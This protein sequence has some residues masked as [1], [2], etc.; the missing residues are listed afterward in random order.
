MIRVLTVDDSAFMRQVLV[1]M[2]Q[3]EGDIS[4]VATAR[5][6]IEAL[7]KQAAL[8]A[9][10]VTLD[11]EMPGLNGIDTLKKLMKIA[12]CPV[13]MISGQTLEGAAATI[14]ALE[15][16]ALDFMAKPAK[17]SCQSLD[18]HGALLREKVRSASLAKLHSTTGLKE[19]KSF[20]VRGRESELVLIGAS[21]G[22]PRA[23]Q[24]IITAL[25]KSLSMPIVIAQHM[26]AAFT[27][28]LAKRLDALSRVSVKEAEDG[29]V[30]QPGI[31]YIGP[32]GK[33]LRIMKKGGAMA[34]GVSEPE[35]NDV[36]HPS[37][38]EL[39]FSVAL[40]PSCKVLAII[41]TGMGKDGAHALA[42]L[43]QRHQCYVL[44]E[45]KET[46]VIYGMPK[47]AVQTGFV[48]ENVPLGLLA[49]R[50]VGRVGGAGNGV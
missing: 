15:A 4:V 40:L 2:L 45:A 50:I 49:S 13:I 27:Q 32:G 22:G 31:I 17:T 12:P 8:Q 43:K 21:T 20:S 36:Y 18:R 23:L 11:I 25:P 1:N 14:E 38:D 42:S 47:A 19:A 29:E 46:A 3:A 33:Q 7:D 16:G 41:L 37:V 48:D 6:G 35:Q 26:P 10:V 28:S 30:L 44:A 34:F 24:T 9:D 5:N 39:F